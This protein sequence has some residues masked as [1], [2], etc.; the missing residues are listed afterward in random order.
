MAGDRGERERGVRTLAVIL[1]TVLGA[2][3]GEPPPRKIAGAD[4][5]RGLR[6]FE[7]EGC[8]TCHEAPDVA[9][10]KG[11]VGGALAGFADR[12]MIAGRFPNQPDTLV[13]WLRDAPALSPETAMPPS[14][15]TEAEARDVAAYLYTLDD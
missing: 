9:W 6:L 4:P 2:C 14:G 7:R 11:R 3:A 12:P 10:P 15:L 13:R 5:E 1:A 8:A